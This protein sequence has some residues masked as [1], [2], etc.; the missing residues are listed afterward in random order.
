M[1]NNNEIDED[2][3]ELEEDIMASPIFILVTLMAYIALSGGKDIPMEQKAE[4]ITL[5]R[6]HVAREEIT[7]NDLRR[8]MRDGFDMTQR[9]EFSSYL[10]KVKPRLSPGQRLC[11]IANLY[12]MMMVDG[13]FL[14]GE[15]SKIDMC[16]R[17]FDLDPV[18]TKQIR[19][20]LIVKNDTGIFFDPT[21]PGNNPD[22]HN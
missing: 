17:S 7:E 14:E 15:K 5:L 12:D 16:R 22:A 8:L 4:F 2:V 18:V 20:V 9:I 1:E 13:E 19:Q 3:L 6:K 11:V 10:E 21:H